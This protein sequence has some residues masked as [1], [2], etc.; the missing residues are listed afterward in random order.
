M[1]MSETYGDEAVS[2]LLVD[3]EQT[4]LIIW[5]TERTQHLRIETKERTCILYHSR[6]SSFAVSRYDMIYTPCVEMSVSRFTTQ[7]H[8]ICTV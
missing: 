6:N 5:H 1:D 3:I 8:S 7:D 2:L 4:D